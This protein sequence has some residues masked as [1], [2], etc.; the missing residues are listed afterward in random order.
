MSNP[1]DKDELREAIAD[2]CRTGH[3]GIAETKVVNNLL[4]LFDHYADQRV[5]EARID[6]RRAFIEDDKAD[7]NATYIA[8]QKQLVTHSHFFDFN[9]HQCSCG[10]SRAEAQEIDRPDSSVLATLKESKDE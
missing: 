2:T 6:E 10:L 4:Q 7:R 5:K 3:Y 9:S 8:K 1:T